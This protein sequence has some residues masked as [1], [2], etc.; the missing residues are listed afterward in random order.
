MIEE[1]NMN[2]SGCIVAQYTKNGEAHGLVEQYTNSVPFDDFKNINPKIKDK[3]LKQK[4]E[5]DRI[6]KIKYINTK[7]RA[8]RL[9]K[10]YCK[11]AG[12][13][14]QKWNFIPGYVYDVPKGLADEVNSIKSVKRSGLCSQDGTE[15]NPLGAPTEKDFVEDGEHLMVAATF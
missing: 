7:G 10:V 2:S 6:V 1:I 14:I 5:D 8:E 12:D 11:W 3:C 13:P 9:P 4:K 15:L